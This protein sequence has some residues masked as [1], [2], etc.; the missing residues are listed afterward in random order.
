MEKVTAQE[1]KKKINEVFVLDVREKDEY[2]QG[3]IAGAVNIPL[4]KLIRD[5][6]YGVPYNKE[7]IVHCRSGHR[8][9]IAVQFLEE[10]GFRNVKNL[11][12]GYNMWEI[13]NS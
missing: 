4:G 10:I 11:D 3:H 9:M 1:L 7:V 12:G 2:D 6:G 5:G 8:S 13:V